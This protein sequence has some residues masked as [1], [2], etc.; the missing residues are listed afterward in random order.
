MAGTGCT[1]H[2]G[3]WIVDAALGIS[4]RISR[5]YS[6]IALHW[7][8]MFYHQVAHAKGLPLASH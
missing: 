1:L 6:R 2:M 8:P 3:V 5:L 7:A 4:P